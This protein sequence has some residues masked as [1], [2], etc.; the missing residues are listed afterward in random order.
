M[1]FGKAFSGI[2]LTVLVG[3]LAA[4]VVALV[5]WSGMGRMEALFTRNE[6]LQR[7]LER[8]QEESVVAYGWLLDAPVGGTLR[9]A[10]LEVPETGAAEGAADFRILELRG[11]EVY[12]EGL[13]VK[14][15]GSLVADGRGRAMIL[16]RRAFGSAE[17][18]EAGVPLETPGEIPTRYRDWLEVEVDRGSRERFWNALWDL[19]H[20]PER[21]AAFEISAV[22][23]NALALQPRP[24]HFYTVKLS[25]T[26]GLGAETRPMREAPPLLRP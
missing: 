13:L 20:D 11:R 3:S 6:A 10:W 17:A 24:G 22:Y 5:V 1:L 12:L 16:W 7:S 18:P 4:A 21:L 15:P 9:F 25:A 19:A 8:L 23:G 14:F 2:R 26:G